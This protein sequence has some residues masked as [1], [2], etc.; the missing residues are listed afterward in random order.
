MTDHTQQIPSRDF[1]SPEER[2]VRQS[3]EHYLASQKRWELPKIGAS[4]YGNIRHSRN[5]DPLSNS[6]T[7]ITELIGLLDAD[8]E[9][10]NER[11]LSEISST[12]SGNTGS[13][14]LLIASALRFD[15]ELKPRDCDENATALPSPPLFPLPFPSFSPIQPSVSYYDLPSPKQNLDSTFRKGIRDKVSHPSLPF[16]PQTFA[17][18]ETPIISTFQRNIPALPEIIHLPISGP[19]PLLAAYPSLQ[20]STSVKAEVKDSFKA[21]LSRFIKRKFQIP[22]P[23]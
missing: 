8:E 20:R 22:S 10:P 1:D 2:T 15:E 21:R 6:N 17:N 7:L 13:S 18:K 9:F 5:S 23:K 4:D 14:D 3:L 16:S 11:P 12:I 19:S